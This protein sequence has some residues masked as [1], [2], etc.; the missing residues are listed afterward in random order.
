MY[1]YYTTIFKFYMK[2]VFLFL[3]FFVSL[4]MQAQLPPAAQ[5]LYNEFY[6]TNTVVA[7][8]C[9][10]NGAQA[11]A[12]ADGKTFYL[13][14]FPAGATPSVTPLMVTLH[15]TGSNAFN[16]LNKWFTSASTHSVGI[17][18]LQWYLGA[19]SSPPNDYFGDTTLYSYID[20]ALQRIK[21]P[22]NKALFHGF[23]RGS[24]R[25]YA[26]QFQDVYPPNGKN[27]FCTIVSNAG[28]PDSL[29]PFYTSINN[30]SNHTF[31][32]GKQWAM[33]CGAADPNPARDGCPGMNSAKT[34]WVIA[35][36]GTVG[37]LIQDPV[38]GHSGLMDTP[39]LQDSVLEFYLPCFSTVSI[40]EYEMK[41]SIELYPNPTSN[42][43]NV[44]T[45]KFVGELIRVF[46]NIGVI[47]KELRIKS[48]KT[49]VDVTELPKGIY[50]LK[51]NNRSTKF[52]RE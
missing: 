47:R 7:Q 13:K 46:D 42:Y 49:T 2:K 3:I 18:A 23:S 26:I 50:F 5:A 51:I 28:K 34:N 25:S 33:Y 41:N 10:N 16:A 37:L 45:E 8:T 27:Y 43:L 44:N 24:A 31:C 12:T 4:K 17:I 32:S 9:I 39:A 29:Y 21:Y 15:G 35:N 19:S 36:G 11:I 14:W 38:L 20:T 22:S 6:N 52:I 48:K 1:F 30:G 40:N